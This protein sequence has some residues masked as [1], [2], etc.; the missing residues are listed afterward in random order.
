MHTLEREPPG[1]GGNLGRSASAAQDKGHW[2]MNINGG[3]VH[4]LAQ[5]RFI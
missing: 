2:Q 5:R 1:Q 3:L 4:H